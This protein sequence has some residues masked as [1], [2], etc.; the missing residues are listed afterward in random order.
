[1]INVIE[2]TFE[3]GPVFMPVVHYHSEVEFW[4]SVE[5]AVKF[6]DGIW[7]I[8]QG[9]VTQKRICEIGEELRS[10]YGPDLFIGVNFLCNNDRAFSKV[11]SMGPI[12]D[13]LWV[14]NAQIDED[15]ESQFAADLFR[16]RMNKSSW[17]GIYFGGTAFKYQKPV[18]DLDLAARYA[19]E[20]MHV[21]TTSGPGTGKQAAPHKV[22]IMRK[23]IDESAGI[24]CTLGMINFPIRASLALASGVSI[25]NVKKYLPYVNAFLVGTSIEDEFGILNELK[26]RELYLAIRDYRSKQR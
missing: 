14:D 6:S 25:K 18:R 20:Y 10:K 21:V 23:A 4:K 9:K 19:S 13:G 2:Y 26:T 22:K 3:K 5:I 17:H 8:R 7:I 12:F 24:G 11:E 16:E 15:D 1:M